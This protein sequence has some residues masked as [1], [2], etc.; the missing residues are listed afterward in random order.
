VGRKR[1]RMSVQPTIP[2]K[3]QAQ[4]QS[5][6]QFQN[7]IASI[8]RSV[9][10]S[11][12]EKRGLAERLADTLTKWFGSMPFLIVNCIWFIVWMLINLEL[13]PGV[14]AFDPFPF[15]LLTMVVS[16]EAI[17]LA[18]IVLISQN[19]AARIADL[20]E[21]VALQVEEISEQEITK[22]LVL[23]KMLL[24]KEGIDISQDEELQAMLRPT[25]TKMLEEA[26]EK[27]V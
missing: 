6:D 5:R 12:D 25:D 27:E 2:S 20:R 10:A 14:P 18:I 23:M 15:G 19:R 3:Y 16:L 22:I 13:I 11:Q 24:E 9:K 21:E 17:I 26:L 1:G 8:R 4:S 7:T